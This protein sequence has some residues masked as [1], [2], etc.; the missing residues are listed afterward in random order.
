[1]NARGDGN[2]WVV[3][4]DG[5]ILAYSSYTGGAGSGGAQCLN[6][7]SLIGYGWRKNYCQAIQFNFICELENNIGKILLR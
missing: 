6:F 5:P 1:M 3:G 4:G 2:N 7:V